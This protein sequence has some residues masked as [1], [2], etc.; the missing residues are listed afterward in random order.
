MLGHD[1]LAA[2]SARVVVAG[3]MESMTNA[4][5]LLAQMRG[6]ARLGH[7]AA[8][9]HMFLDGLEDAYEPGR[10][11]GDLRRGLR[12]EFQFTRADQDDYALASLHARARRAGLGRLRRRDRPRDGRGPPRRDGRPRT[13]ARGPR[14]REDPAP[15]A[16]LPERRHGDGGQRL[17]D[18][19]RRRGAGAD[20]RGRRAGRRPADPGAAARPRRPRAGAGAVSDRA[21]ARRRRSCWRGSAGARGT[22]I[23]GR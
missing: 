14:A 9:D 22:S 3:G 7:A 23:S 16:R 17:V 15:E 6:G 12:D 4:P 18:L 21:R 20:A 13:K 1:A 2:G 10:L 19:R 11:M 8:Q 5:Y